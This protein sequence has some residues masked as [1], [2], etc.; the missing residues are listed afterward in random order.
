M[1]IY[2]LAEGGE[3]N[4]DKPKKR[5]AALRAA[6]L[7]L[8]FDFVLTQA[9][10]AI[11]KNQEDSMR[12]SFLLHLFKKLLVAYDTIPISICYVKHINNTWDLIGYSL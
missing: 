10:A 2:F 8:G 3:I 4:N 6:I 12:E 11:Q 7:F 1:Q 5:M 9:T